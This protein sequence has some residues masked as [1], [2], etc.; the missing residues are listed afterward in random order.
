MRSHNGEGQ[1]IGYC[2]PMWETWDVQPTLNAPGILV[3]CR[4]IIPG[5]DGEGSFPRTV[6]SHRPPDVEPAR[7]LSKSAASAPSHNLVT[8]ISDLLI[9]TP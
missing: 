7:D 9:N 6:A 5:T 1:L 4:L 8:S 3:S 2:L